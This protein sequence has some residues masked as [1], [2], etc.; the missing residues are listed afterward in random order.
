MKTNTLNFFLTLLFILTIIQGI[1]S[2]SDSLIVEK[3]R[4]GNRSKFKIDNTTLSIKD[5]NQ[6][7]SRYSDAQYEFTKARNNRSASIILTISGA[8]LAGFYLAMA[9]EDPFLYQP[10]PIYIGIGLVCVSIP[11]NSAYNKRARKAMDIYNANL[12]KK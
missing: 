3:K 2:Q 4:F 6:K 12:K 7:Y 1:Y 9:N 10:A 5:L 11:L 8:V